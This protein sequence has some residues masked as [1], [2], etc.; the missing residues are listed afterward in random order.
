MEIQSER[1][2]KNIHD[3][4]SFLHHMVSDIWVNIGSGNSLLLVSQ[5]VSDTKIHLK[6]L[7]YNSYTD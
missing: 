2:E 1:D 4:N 5:D 3:V 6:M 7:P